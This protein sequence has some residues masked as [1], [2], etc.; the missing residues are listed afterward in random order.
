MG[1]NP[2]NITSD[3]HGLSGI[4]EAESAAP[5]ESFA[6]VNGAWR[7][8]LNGSIIAPPGWYDDAGGRR[9][10]VA[11]GGIL[12][13]RGWHIADG[14]ERFFL[15]GSVPASGWVNANGVMALFDEKGL[16]IE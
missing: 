9:R 10:Y 5:D 4:T 15:E 16:R 1:G 6:F 11:D 2:M 7:Y 12:L 13:T 3:T 14:A 8:V